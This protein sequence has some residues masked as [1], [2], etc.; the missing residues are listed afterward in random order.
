MQISYGAKDP[1]LENKKHFYATVPTEVLLNRVR[2]ELLQKFNWSK[3]AV[4]A[5]RE[6]HYALVSYDSHS[7]IHHMISCNQPPIDS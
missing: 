1:D 4:L 7:Y 3:V 6:E 2:V 5:S